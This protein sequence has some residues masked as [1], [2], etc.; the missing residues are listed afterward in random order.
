MRVLVTGS[1]GHL[2]EALMRTLLAQEREAVGLDIIASPYTHTV[3]SIADRAF[4]DR[5]VRDV[6][7]VLHTATLHKPH[8]A[9]WPLPPRN[10]TREH[11]QQR[12]D[13]PA[14]SASERFGLC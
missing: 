10:A 6:K 9:T 13:Q 5:A 7:A 1:A 4:V 3:G 14:T 8:I 2:G 12:D 11:E